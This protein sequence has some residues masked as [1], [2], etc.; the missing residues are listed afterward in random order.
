[1]FVDGLMLVGG[2]MFGRWVGG[3][4]FGRWVGG[5]MFVGR[6]ILLGVAQELN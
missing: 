5:L 1:M 2:L 4:T 3:L 6:L